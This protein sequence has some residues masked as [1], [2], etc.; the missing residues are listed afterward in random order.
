MWREYLAR[1][2]NAAGAAEAKTALDLL[3]GKALA[4]AELAASRHGWWSYVRDFPEGT[5]AAKARLAL[6]KFPAAPAP[7][8]VLKRLAT[9]TEGSLFLGDLATIECQVGWGTLR[10]NEGGEVQILGERCERFISPHPPSRVVYG[11]PEAFTRFTAIGT[12]F[13]AREAAHGT[14]RYEVRIDDQQVFQSKALHDEPDGIPIELP[15][16]EGAKRLEIRIDDYGDAY[17]DWAVLAQPLF[18]RQ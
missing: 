3:D 7:A 13:N 10:V 18:H 14:W 12:R 9:P 17:Y 1:Y 15:L 5:G 2:P 6:E 8:E 4:R 16:P 11:I